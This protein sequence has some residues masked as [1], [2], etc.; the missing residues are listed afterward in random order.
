[1]Q[2]KNILYTK[3]NIIYNMKSLIS[4]LNESLSIN[5][6]MDSTLAEALAK[7]PRHKDA[8]N[9]IQSALDKWDKM[10]KSAQQKFAKLELLSDMASSSEAK[11]CAEAVDL[12]F[13]Y[14]ISAYEN[15]MEDLEQ[16]S[17][18][19]DPKKFIEWFINDAGYIDML[20]DDYRMDSS[21]VEQVKEMLHDFKL[22]KDII[23]A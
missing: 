20:S 6:A 8:I 19:S 7:F 11:E 14:I 2:K 1:M 13:A 18:G 15:M 16:Y 21:I 10:S 17:Y 9:T 5:E 22:F 4:Q 3:A 12:I 23:G